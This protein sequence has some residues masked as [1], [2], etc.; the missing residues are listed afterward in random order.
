MR[1]VPAAAFSLLSAAAVRT[2]AHRLLAIG[3]D[4]RLD[5]FC[6]DP[7]KLDDVADLVIEVTR[8]AYPTLDVPF[9]SRWRHFVAD[10]ADRWDRLQRA[11]GWR[12]AGERARAEFDLAIVSVL[13]DAGAGPD[14]TYRDPASG[15]R[16]GRSEGLALASLDML[17]AGAFSS[18]PRQPLRVDAA[19]LQG[20]S[21]ETLC[22]RFQVDAGNPLLGVEGRVALLRRLGAT[23]AA[24]PEV[25]ACADTP[26]PGGLFDHLTANAVDRSIAAP[27]VLS[28][29]LRHLGQVWPSR[30]E[31]EGV[32]LGDCWRHPALK[33]DDATAGLMPLHK[34]SQ[35]L[36]YSLLEP[37]Q[38]AGLAIT[39]VDGLTGL[40]EYRNG[41]LFIDTDVLALRDPDDARRPHAVDSI[42]VVEWRALTVAL[43]DRVAAL[44]RQRL[45]M[46]AETLPLAKVL[47]GGT[48]A[49]GRRI[50]RKLRPDGSPPL[51]VV[52][53]GT[54]F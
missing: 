42:L 1:P 21:S 10:G 53:D 48:W 25:F 30:L 24:A 38:T 50:A 26:R 13:L 5:H 41:G 20:M 43:L 31:L 52:S 32:P 40:A 54:V 22:R 17:A 51:A 27:T 7:G 11:H 33:A 29:V 35:W 4:G 46:D 39:D 9:H 16:V 19:A 15:A 18:D 8:A 2:R 12:G 47:Q 36:T 14:W 49:A 28:A 34:L 6:I 3:L 23:V 37:L 44:I 45:G